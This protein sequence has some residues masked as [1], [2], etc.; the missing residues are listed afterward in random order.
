[1][2]FFSLVPRIKT[3]CREN[4]LVSTVYTQFVECISPLHIM[5]AQN[6]CLPCWPKFADYLTF[7][8]RNHGKDCQLM[9]LEQVKPSQAG[10]LS[11]LP[12]IAFKM[13]IYMP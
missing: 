6:T 10:R 1:M 13:R 11:R 8:L 7:A 4:S 12:F 5:C 2:E 9:L 3:L